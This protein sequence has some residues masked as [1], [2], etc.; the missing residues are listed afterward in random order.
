MFEQKV[1]VLDMQTFF[2][3]D[4]YLLFKLIA[5]CTATL[6]FQ[7][8]GGGGKTE[9]SPCLNWPIGPLYCKTLPLF[10]FMIN[11]DESARNFTC[12]ANP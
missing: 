1:D 10:G 11:L 12:K 4:F 7:K 9:K 3:N 6:I 2:S 5:I 8:N